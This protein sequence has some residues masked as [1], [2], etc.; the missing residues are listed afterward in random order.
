MQ[1]RGRKGVLWYIALCAPAP[2]PQPPPL[3]KTRPPGAPSTPELR[4]NVQRAAYMLCRMSSAVSQPSGALP[5]QNF[6]TCVTPDVSTALLF[7]F[8]DRPPPP[9]AAGSKATCGGGGGSRTRKR[10]EAGCGRPED[11]GVWTAKTVKRPPQQPAQPQYANYWAPLTRKRHTMPHPAQPQH[12][13]H[14]PPR[15]RKRHQQD[16]RPQRPTE[17]SDPTQRA[18]GRTGDCPGPRKGATTRRNVTRGGGGGA[19]FSCG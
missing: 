2:T 17:S 14:W 6:N 7:T 10:S 9:P 15:T 18:K 16:H 3:Q 1:S 11:G 13:H 12:T 19:G 4:P 5:P 8:M